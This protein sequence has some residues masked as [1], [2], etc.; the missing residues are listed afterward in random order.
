M[1]GKRNPAAAAAQNQAHVD[2]L[3][4]VLLASLEP[5]KLQHMSQQTKRTVRDCGFN[6]EEVME[7]D[8]EIDNGGDVEELQSHFTTTPQVT[9]YNTE[10]DYT[11]LSG[12]GCD[13]A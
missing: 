7:W 8:G 11:F 13:H 1:E 10:E 5:P 12:A 4:A 9:S 6:Q 2:A 3:Y